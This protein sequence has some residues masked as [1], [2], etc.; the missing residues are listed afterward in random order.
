MCGHFGYITK[1]PLT[2]LADKRN[3]LSQ[4]TVFDTVRGDDSTGVYLLGAKGEEYLYKRALAG[5]DFIRLHNVKTALWKIDP[6]VAM[7]HNRAATKGAVN[8]SNAH[9]FE[10]DGIVMTHNGTL[11][12]FHALEGKKDFSVDSEWLCHSIANRGIEETAKLVTGAFALAYLN[13]ETGKFYLITNGERPL[14]FAF[15]ED[16][17]T[18]Y[19]SSEGPMMASTCHRN[20]IDLKD[21]KY[22]ACKKGVLYEFDVDEPTSV[23]ETEVELHSYKKR[24][25]YPAHQGA[26]SVGKKTTF[27]AILDKVGL[28]FGQELTLAYL[29]SD[30][31]VFSIDFLVLSPED[32]YKNVQHLDVRYVAKTEEEFYKLLNNADR[33]YTGC[34]Q[35]G[36]SLGDVQGKGDTIYLRNLLTTKESLPDGIYEDTPG[37]NMLPGPN[38]IYVPLE[39]FKHLVKDGCWQCGDEIDELEAGE[40]EWTKAA[41]GAPSKPIC[42]NCVEEWE[43]YVR[44]HS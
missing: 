38:G 36:L 26:S 12:N 28:H 18:M 20:K 9:P 4:M 24:T 43:Q 2:Q 15:S 32:V 42:G 19:Y 37:D 33:I 29:D 34:V 7:G 40:L 22:T 35:A 14:H 21:N 23:T 11:N 30:P 5:Y 44:K 8:D 41:D 17:N 10:F 3:Y 27:K 39:E 1:T 13:K 31:N 25:Y 16:E 6:R